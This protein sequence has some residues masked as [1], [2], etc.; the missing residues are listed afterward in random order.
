MNALET[1][2]RT[3]SL[4]ERQI[5]IVAGVCRGLSNLEIGMEMFYALFGALYAVSY[6]S[7]H[8]VIAEIRDRYTRIPVDGLTVGDVLFRAWMF[9]PSMVA[10]A[11]L[12]TGRFLFRVLDFKVIDTRKKVQNVRK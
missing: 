1:F 11:F 6:C 5:K 3:F 7:G 12:F 4:T 10:I 9:I 8:Y 2:L